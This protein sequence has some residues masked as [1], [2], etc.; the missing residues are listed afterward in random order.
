[1]TYLTYEQILLM[2]S[3]AIDETGGLH[4]VRDPHALFMLQDLPRQKA[5][6]KELYEG[7]FKKSALYARIII[8]SHPFFD[9]N[10]RTAM[11]AAG[12]FIENNG[13][14]IFAEEGEIEKLAIDVATKKYNL[15]SIAEWFE[16]HSQKFDA[17]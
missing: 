8:E 13:Y 9:G 10:K 14:K 1:M 4:G 11:L 15:E 5:F 16:K 7:I 6:G 12:T 2:H 3:M 17:R